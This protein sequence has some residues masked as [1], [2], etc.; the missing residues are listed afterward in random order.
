ML[1]FQAKQAMMGSKRNML[2]MNGMYIPFGAL[3]L[4]MYDKALINYRIKMAS[5]NS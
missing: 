1:I 2:L 5:E 4:V 3:M